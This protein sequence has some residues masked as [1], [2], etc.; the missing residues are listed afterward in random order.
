MGVRVARLG[1]AGGQGVLV[2]GEPGLSA[3]TWDQ[4]DHPG[5]TDQ[6]GHRR[7]R[8]RSGGRPPAFDPE[9]YKQRHAVEC[10][11][12]RLKRNRAVAA[13]YDKLAV[14]Y[15]AVLVIA[16]INEWLPRL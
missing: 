16:S 5:A 6:A 7:R 3:A 9:I 11:T 8:G 10:G 13:R 15:E 2:A 1:G 14:R 4:G 12:N